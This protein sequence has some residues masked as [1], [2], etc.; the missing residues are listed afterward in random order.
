MSKSY[1]LRVYKSFKKER[2]LW[3]EDDI[4]KINEKITSL[5]H[6]PRPDGCKK[7]SGNS[8]NYRIR[9]GKYR[10]IYTI[11]EEEILVLIVK[12]DMRKDSY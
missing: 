11:E 3:P 4:K 8:G 7:L 12:V 6:N 5:R 2:E 1:E 9:Y 10:I